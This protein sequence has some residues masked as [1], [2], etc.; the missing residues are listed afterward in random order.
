MEDLASQKTILVVD[1]EDGVRESVREV[2]TDEGYR[3]LDT[4][5]GTQVLAMIK[6]ERPELV[7][8]DIWMPQ[9]D[10]IGLLREIKSQIPMSTL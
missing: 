9:V 6:A 1:D 8:L 2:L 7:L 4:A 5:D 3:V 10:G